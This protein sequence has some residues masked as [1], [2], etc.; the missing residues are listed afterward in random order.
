MKEL[1]TERHHQNE[2]PVDA[3]GG[4]FVLYYSFFIFQSSVFIFLDRI[5]K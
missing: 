2:N 1:K 5:F 4:I 3:V